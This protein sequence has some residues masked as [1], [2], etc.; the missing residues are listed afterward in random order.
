VAEVTAHEDEAGWIGACAGEAGD[1]VDCVLWCRLAE[2]LEDLAF[3]SRL[4]SQ[5]NKSCRRRSSRR[6]GSHQS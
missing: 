2:S 3:H 5:V 6:H 4:E 1:V